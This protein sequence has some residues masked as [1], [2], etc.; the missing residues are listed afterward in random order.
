MGPVGGPETSA[1]YYHYVL[2]NNSEQRRSHLH[3]GGSL[4]SLI[5]L[6]KLY[7]S[8]HFQYR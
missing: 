6:H 8:N 5:S 3:R 7:S 1:R 2:R 4:K